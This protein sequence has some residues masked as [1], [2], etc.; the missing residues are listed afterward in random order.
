MT[1]SFMKKK[2]ALEETGDGLILSTDRVIG[3]DAAETNLVRAGDT[4][5]TSTS[6]IN[7]GNIDLRSVM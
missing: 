4:L 7:T 5:S 2:Q 6:W 3:A 1:S